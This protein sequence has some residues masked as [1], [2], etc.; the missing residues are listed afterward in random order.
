MDWRNVGE[1]V[2]VQV[3]EDK[4]EVLIRLSTNAPTRVS[5]SGKSQ[6]LATTHGFV[7]VPGTDLRISLN[8]I[9]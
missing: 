9:R 5:K 2:A 7:A 4:R 1:N 6:V 8:V 3:S